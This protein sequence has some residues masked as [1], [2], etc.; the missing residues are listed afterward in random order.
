MSNKSAQHY[1]QER[2]I[3]F[4]SLFICFERERKKEREHEGQAEGK[5][6]RESEAGSMLSTQSLMWGLIP[7]TMRS[8]AEP[9]SRVGGSLSHPG[10]YFTEERKDVWPLVMTYTS[11]THSF[12]STIVYPFT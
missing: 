2:R 6:V 9:K 10:D 5:G 12:D 4:L 7:R 11:Y 8:R 3:F 1:T